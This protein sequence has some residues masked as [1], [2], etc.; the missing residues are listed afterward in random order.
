M[1]TRRAAAKADVL[2]G[3]AYR[4]DAGRFYLTGKLWP[5]IFEVS[6]E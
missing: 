5:S 2:N 1:R 4:P 6:F 3:I